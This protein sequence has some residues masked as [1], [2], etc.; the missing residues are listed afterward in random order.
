MPLIIDVK[1]SYKNM[2]DP[3]E[4]MWDPNGNVYVYPKKPGKGTLSFRLRNKKKLKKTFEIL[5][6]DPDFESSIVSYNTRNNYFSIRFENYG[7]GDLKISSGA[8]MINFDYKSYDRSVRCGG[9]TIKPGKSKTVKFYVNG[10]HTYPNE[11][12]FRMDFTF[13]YYG[14]RYSARAYIGG[15]EY[16]KGKKWVDTCA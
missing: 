12:R 11:E 2:I 16:K 4:W 7:I 10:S 5:P 13:S 9:L 6:P 3:D 1:S 15:S 8:K 14:K